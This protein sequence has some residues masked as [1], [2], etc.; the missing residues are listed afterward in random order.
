MQRLIV[1]ICFFITINALGQSK[2]PVTVTDMLKIRS[3]GNVTLSPDGSKA[4][5][6]VTAIESDAE[7][8]W[9]YKYVTQIWMVL[10][11]GPSTPRQLTTKESAA[12]P[13]WSPDGKQLAFTRAID[14]KAQI[15]LLS[16]DGGEAVQLTKF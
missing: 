4:A 7:T 8:K 15:F 9:D 3:I 1:C 16:L 2:Q 5:F 13:A 6:T 10:T 12:Q 14:G 11:D